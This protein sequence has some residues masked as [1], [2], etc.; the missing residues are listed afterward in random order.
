MFRLK[1]GSRECATCD[2]HND[3]RI[4]RVSTTETRRGGRYGLPNTDSYRSN[5]DHG[6][7]SADLRRGNGRIELTTDG[8]HA[9]GLRP[10]RPDRPREDSA[11]SLQSGES[12]WRALLD[13]VDHDLALCLSILEECVRLADGRQI[14]A[15]SRALLMSS[16]CWSLDPSIW[17]HFR[18][19][20]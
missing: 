13:D 3:A 7:R 18:S 15:S 2:L 6:M 20:S 14:E 5:S 4:L 16:P 9:L 19:L 17:P 11:K 1:C 12:T 8:L 10:E